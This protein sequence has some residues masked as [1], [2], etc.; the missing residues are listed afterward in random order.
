MRSFREKTTSGVFWSVAGQMGRQS[1]LLLTQVLLARLL[2]P[3]DF[4]LVATVLIFSNFAVIVA[5]QGFGA[6]LIQRP[7]I[8]ERH[9]S[10]IYWVNVA[11]GAGLT[12]LFILAAPLIARAYGE[13]ALLPL[14]RAMAVMFVLHSAGMLHT[15]LLS[16]ALEFKRVAR[17]EVAAAWAGG[18]VAVVLALKGAGAWA[19]VAQSLVT[20]GVGSFMLW[21]LSSWR[22]RFLFDLAAVRELAGF[23]TNHFVG[24]I[25]NYWVRNVDNV[26]IGLVLG[27]HPLGVYTRAYAVMLFPLSRVTRVLSRVMLPSFSLIQK[28]PERVRGLFLRMTRV[29]ALATF[30][31]MLGV[32]ACAPDFVAA[33][34][35]PQW[36]EMVPVL[37]VL[38]F[39]GMVQSVTSLMSNLY[40]SQN[41]TDLRLRV[42][43]PMQALEVAAIVYGLRHGILGV[44]VCY[45][46]ASM[47][48]APVN[49]RFAGG[50]VGMG[51]GAFCRNL[52]PIFGCAAASGAGGA[53]AAGATAGAAPARLAEVACSARARSA[54]RRPVLDGRLARLPRGNHAPAGR[55]QGGRRVR[56]LL[57]AVMLL[58]ACT[59]APRRAFPV[60][61]L[62]PLEA[63]GLS[64]AARLG[65]HVALEAPAGAALEPAGDEK[66][67]TKTSSA[68]FFAGT[69]AAVRG[70][71]GVYFV[72]PRFTAPYG[73]TDY[74]EEWQAM[75]RAAARLT[76]LRPVIEGGAEAPAPFAVPA[77]LEA[78]AWRLRGRLY[79]ALVNDGPAPVPLAPEALER[80]RALF[81]PRADAREALVACDA[82]LCLPPR[83]ALWLEGRPGAR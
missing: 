28:E 15:T 32:A 26:L 2:A 17:A 64:E 78:R 3:R 12:T 58:G 37:R 54:C 24:N 80:W 41:R 27:A 5:E 35:G 47:L 55:A 48:T 76:A 69:R 25:A 29:I 61:L 21:R 50:L 7:D 20:A 45:A 46:A 56:R 38:A 57:A 30:P 22:P 14:T 31:M 16:R 13:P 43:L 8:E 23:S 19:I 6:A 33:V 39:V 36:G 4:G 65:L 18:A 44:A 70:A 82:A 62:G 52:A 73:W 11:F 60:G 42:V 67:Q 40:L 77:G 68:L 10:S 9:R 66:E 49:T 53:A 81:E 72:P 79:V 71:L 83:R 1:V 51:V 63:K 74:P 59:P 34:F 75:A